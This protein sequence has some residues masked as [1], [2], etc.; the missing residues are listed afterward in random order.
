MIYLLCSHGLLIRIRGSAQCDDA[1]AVELSALISRGN[2]AAVSAPR[3]LF[4]SNVQ[5]PLEQ[6]LQRLLRYREKAYE[7]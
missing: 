5:W 2:V 1:S 6:W 3:G 7:L 4:W